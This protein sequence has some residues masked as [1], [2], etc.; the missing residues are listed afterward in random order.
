MTQ[1]AT[2]EKCR[3]EFEQKDSGL[4]DL[5]VPG[6]S[7]VDL[8]SFWNAIRLAPF[9]LQTFRDG[10]ALEIPET[11]EWVFQ[12]RMVASVMAR[13]KAGKAS[14]NCHFFGGDLELDVEPREVC[15]EVEFESMLCVMRVITHALNRPM[16]AVPEGA[17]LSD[18]FLRVMPD[19]TCEYLST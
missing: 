12:E 11:N 1:P 8:V 19:G 9:G 18:A 3:R 5:I 17:S 10:I 15:D 14:I 2:W 13:I 7:E 16:Y 6:T 4:I